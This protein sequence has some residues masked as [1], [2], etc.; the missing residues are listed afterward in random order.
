[1]KNFLSLIAV[2][3]VGFILLGCGGNELAQT[4][5]LD[6]TPETGEEK[7]FIATWSLTDENYVDHELTF[8]SEFDDRYIYSYIFPVFLEAGTYHL[9]MN[10]TGVDGP[11]SIGISP[12]PINRNFGFLSERNTLNN[13]G[14]TIGFASFGASNSTALTNTAILIIIEDGYFSLN[15]EA[16][17]NYDGQ[18]FDSMSLYRVD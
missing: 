17:E 2:L 14:E 8:Y 10:S 15:H 1:L 13:Y 5:G 18:H 7:T 6:V 11:A 4:T 3:F 9:V 12:H 16:L